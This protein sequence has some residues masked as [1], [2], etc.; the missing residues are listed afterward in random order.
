MVKGIINF[1]YGNVPVMNLA[2]GKSACTRRV[3][4]SDCADREAQAF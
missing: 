1:Y 2:G 4:C 3:S